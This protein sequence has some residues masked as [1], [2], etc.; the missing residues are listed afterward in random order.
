MSGMGA[1]YHRDGEGVLRTDMDRMKASLHVHGPKKQTNSV[2][3]PVG[4][5]WTRGEEFTPQDRFDHQ[6]LLSEG[7]WSIAFHGV[8]CKREELAT[9]VGVTARQLQDMPDSALF[10]AAWRKWQAEALG[11]VHGDYAF[12]LFDDQTNTLTA[13]RSE[14]GALPIFYHVRDRRLVLGSA[15]KA[16][17]S[18]R[19]IDRQIDEVKIADSLV[20]N[21]QDTESS[22]YKGIKSLPLGCLLECQGNR[23][24]IRRHYDL[25][26][27]Q[28][29]RFKNDQ[30]YVDAANDLF[31]VAVRDAMRSP[32]PAAASLS[33]GLDSSAV[34][35][36]ML[37]QMQ[38]NGITEKLD[39]Y[40]CVPGPDWDK[41]V[42]NSATIGDESEAV[43]AL[44]KMYPKIDAHFLDAAGQSIDHDHD[45]MLL[46]AEAPQ[47]AVNNL[48]WVIN[49]QRR[50]RQDG[51]TSI[52][53]GA[54]GN[55]TLSFSGQALLAKLLRQGRW[56]KLVQELRANEGNIG[57]L[58]TAYRKA[59]SPHLPRA[60]VQGIR[61][62]FGKNGPSGWKTHSAINPDFAHDMGTV[63]RMANMGWDDAAS[64][65][66]APRSMM[67]LMLT[68]GI[69]DF[70]QSTKAALEVLT[71]VQHRDPLGSRELVEFC[72]GL[73]D[74]QF[75]DNGEDRRLIKRMM[76]GR[77]PP[78]YFRGHRGIQAADWHARVTADLPRYKKELERM[79]DDPDAARRFDMPRLRN[80][81][82]T[83]PKTTPHSMDD[84]PDFK[85]AS[86]GM[87]R[88]IST[89]RWIN[90]VE[91]K[92]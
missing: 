10:M 80:L 42:R 52:L 79:S 58:H 56:I 26:Q 57:A 71:G 65:L 68:T 49:M 83:W 54:S 89:S 17:F 29:V 23:L 72:Y 84:H 64:G 78:E 60:L 16:I 31:G 70:G 28:D 61:S 81:V 15:P 24:Q 86:N 47:F 90:W 4:L 55:A 38:A 3:G 67:E 45:K 63:A 40:T 9:K 20:L 5:A 1:I 27:V 21:Y 43:R 66:K 12:I 88:A 77:L 30:D 2:A 35:V 41:T 91:G 69:R 34:V 32:T 51:H 25:S 36:E 53:G 44:A 76:A 92:N 18:L 19:D 7:R 74:D 46:L 85:L 59:V 33:A 62:V 73:P 48:H 50:A 22:F 8:L 13:A 75:L 37:E 87:M 14:M 82:K 6:P 39:T 11:H